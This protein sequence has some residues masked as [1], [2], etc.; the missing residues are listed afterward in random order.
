MEKILAPEKEE[1]TVPNILDST[2]EEIS[3]EDMETEEEPQ[4]IPNVT[5]EFF[6]Q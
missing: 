4:W 5:P 6:D 2:D 1:K 3:D